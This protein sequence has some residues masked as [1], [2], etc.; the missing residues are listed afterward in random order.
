MEQVQIANDE[1]AFHSLSF[2]DH[3][4]RLFEWQGDIYRAIPAHQ[5]P[6]YQDLLQKGIIR[7]LVSQKL[8]IE[9]ELT[10][11]KVENY[12]LVLKHRKIDFVSYPKEWCSEML[13]DAAL[14]HLDFCLELE[15]YGL[16]TGDANPLNILFDGCQPIF[17]DLGSI[18]QIGEHSH[19]LW[20]AYNQFCR[21]FINPLGLMTQGQGR[22]ARWLI[23][24]YEQGIL[25]EDVT[26]LT[27]KSPLS[28]LQKNGRN[29]LKS[30]LQHRL[31]DVVL[32]WAKQIRDRARPLFTSTNKSLS[33]RAFFEQTRQEILNID[34]ATLPTKSANSSIDQPTVFLANNSQQAKFQLVASI[35]SDL[36]PASVLEIGNS[37]S[38]GDYAQLAAQKANQVV[39]LTP[40]ESKAEQLYLHGKQN[41]LPILP[42]LMNFMSPSSDLSNA[43]FAPAGDR[44]SC[45]L[46]LAL[47]LIDWL[48]FEQPQCFPFD[49]IVERIAVFSKRWLLTE[50]VTINP[51]HSEALSPD[52]KYIFSW[53][54][55][56]NFIAA[57]HR[58]FH[59]VDTIERVS[60]SSVLILCQK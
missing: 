47:D 33:R 58:E 30:T 5:T 18:E 28:L 23:Q 41:Q 13:K 7:Q 37:N 1:L 29:W 43:W 42:L 4:G 22:I 10:P 26:A 60:E 19:S 53:Y 20:S 24:D 57:L 21:C 27:D 34:C 51:P 56:D 14:L 3:N 45:E 52:L 16:I 17:I 55:L 11:L 8:L 9:T 44:L 46:T 15:R 31:P 2:N 25:P 59:Q 12:A 38:D 39:F 35:L 54:N 40:E 50:F 49:R 32:P 6:L 48:V 36:Q